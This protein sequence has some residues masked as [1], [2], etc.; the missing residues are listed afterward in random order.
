MRIVEANDDDGPELA[1]FV[2]D[3]PVGAGT[4]FVL[5]RSPDFTALLKLRGTSRT[6]CARQGDRLL[7]I[8]TALWDERTDRDMTVRVGEFVDLRVTRIARGGPAARALLFAVLGAF[9]DVGIDWL[10]AVIGD[11]N[12]AATGLVR[13]KAGLPRLRSLTHY[14]SVHMVALRTPRVMDGRIEVREATEADA[15]ILQ[16]A[17]GRVHRPLRLA[18]V[19]PFEWP[20]PTARH[21]AWIAD[22]P[23][24]EP[25]GVLMIWDGF[26]VRRIRVARY[27]GTDRLLRRITLALEP[28]GLSAALPPPGGAVR[29]WGSRVFWNRTGAPAVTRALVNA[30]LRAAAA[31]GVHVVQFNLMEEDPLLA[32]LPPYPRSSFGSTLFG[33]PR[34]RGHAMDASA[35]ASAFHA[36][37]AMI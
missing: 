4:D 29:M 25:L 26:D 36:D 23:S 16:R 30:S 8:A 19:T 13:G 20:D 27:H 9:D 31:A 17:A 33:A 15:A 35:P 2:L 6:F 12:R 28:L 3:T 34:E 24:R 5:D 32:Q 22:H 11:G 10:T 18:P 37:L 7:G 1:D 21:R 14:R